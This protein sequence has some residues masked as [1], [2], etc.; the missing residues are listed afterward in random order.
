MS[1][2]KVGDKSCIAEA[3]VCPPK[4]GGLG[5]D[6]SSRLRGSLLLPTIAKM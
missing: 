2:P 6:V 5:A 3:P 4:P 1:L